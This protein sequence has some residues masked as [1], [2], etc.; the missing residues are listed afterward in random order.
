MWSFL[1]STAEHLNS[2]RTVP[3][4]GWLSFLIPPILLC[5]L[6][7]TVVALLP[8]ARLFVWPVA[9]SLSLGVM[10][11]QLWPAPAPVVLAQAP[12]AQTAPMPRDHSDCPQGAIVLCGASGDQV[13][14]N[15]V[16]NSPVGIVDAYGH[17]N[18][19]NQNLLQN[20][21]PRLPQ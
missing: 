9:G 13:Y 20:V 19:I 14:G 11:F 18:G 6:A 17:G 7:G 8:P 15:I 10:A 16:Q 21:G 12:P 4:L 1:L 5:G 3:G 2:L